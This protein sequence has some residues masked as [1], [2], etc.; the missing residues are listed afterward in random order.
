MGNIRWPFRCN[1]CGKQQ[2]R[3]VRTGIY[4]KCKRCGHPNPG[5][6]MVGGLATAGLPRSPVKR[7]ASQSPQ[8]AATVLGPGADPSPGHAP[9]PAHPTPP[10]ANPT[11]HTPAGPGSIFDRVRQ[12]GRAAVYGEEAAAAK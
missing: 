1:N 4:V 9:T 8:P 7:K 3:R 12:L 5:P 6:R 10:P 2:T 11:P